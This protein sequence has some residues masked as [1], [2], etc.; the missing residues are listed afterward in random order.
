MQAR[1]IISMT[2]AFCAGFGAL[3]MSQ[4]VAKWAWWLGQVMVIA[5]PIMM[6]ARAVSSKKPPEP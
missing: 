2:G 4:P 1:D 6:S 3:L 5:G